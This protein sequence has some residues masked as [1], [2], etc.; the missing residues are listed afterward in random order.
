MGWIKNLGRTGWGGLAPTAP[1]ALGLSVFFVVT[2]LLAG[3]A[4]PE[5]GAGGVPSVCAG[6]H[7]GDGE[8]R[9]FDL[10]GAERGYREFKET[11]SQSFSKSLRDHAAKAAAPVGYD[12]GLPAGSKAGTRRV[13]PAKALPQALLGRKFWFFAVPAGKSPKI[14]AEVMSDPDVVPLAAKVE[15]LQDLAQVSKIIGRPASL[16]PKGLGEALGVR[17]IPALVTISKEGEV[18]IHDDP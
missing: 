15:K 9:V 6:W 5:E 11:V 1:A 17:L 12:A 4:S 2:T 3:A 16:A 13:T 10:A 14:P 18:E 8:S 7:R